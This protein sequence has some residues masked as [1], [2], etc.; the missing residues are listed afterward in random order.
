L[1]TRPNFNDNNVTHLI[2]PILQSQLN[3]AEYLLLNLL[4]NL[5]QS[6]KQVKLEALATAQAYRLHLRVGKKNERGFHPAATN[7]GKLVS[8]TRVVK[9]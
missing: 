6:I 5:L 9:S 8:N 4:I 7:T 1:S 3:R 2:K